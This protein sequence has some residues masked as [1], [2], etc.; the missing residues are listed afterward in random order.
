MYQTITVYLIYGSLL[1]M[2]MLK[3]TICECA[4]H[5][6]PTVKKMLKLFGVKSIEELKACVEKAKFDKTARYEN[7]WESAPNILSYIIVEEIASKN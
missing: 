1:C 6:N 3:I 2:D 7:A 5:L 4:C